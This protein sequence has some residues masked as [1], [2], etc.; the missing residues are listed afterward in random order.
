MMDAEH[1]SAIIS[2]FAVIGGVVAGPGL[3]WFKEWWVKREKIDK[4][5]T[6]LAI[7]VAS[8]LNRFATGCLDVSHDDGTIEGRPSGKTGHNETTTE[9]PAFRPLE[10]DVDWKLLPKDLLYSILRVPDQLDQLER[11]IS[12]IWQFEFDPPDHVVYFQARRRGYAVLGLQA[13]EAAKKLLSQSGLQTDESDEDEWSR[14]KSLKS[15][16]SDIDAKRSA[17]FSQKLSLPEL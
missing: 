5:K 2:A 12:G 17:Y 13:S 14:D 1:V 15:V 7:I 3:V 6:Y 8:H 4:D 10:L 16:I 11:E 9:P